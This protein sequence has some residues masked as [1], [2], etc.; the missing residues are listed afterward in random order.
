MIHVVAKYM[1]QGDLLNFGQLWQRKPHCGSNFTS[2]EESKK[3]RPFYGCL[4][5]IFIFKTI[6]LF[7]MTV[8]GVI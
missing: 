1:S 3:A 7:G 5:N 2:D 8:I 6:K 4:N